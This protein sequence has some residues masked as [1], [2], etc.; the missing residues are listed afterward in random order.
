MCFNINRNR[1]LLGIIVENH[2]QRLEFT[3]TLCWIFIVEYWNNQPLVQDFML[4]V[5]CA[6]TQLDHLFLRGNRCASLAL[7]FSQVLCLLYMCTFPVHCWLRGVSFNKTAYCCH[8]HS[9]DG[10]T[11]RHVSRFVSPFGENRIHQNDQDMSWFLCLIT[12]GDVLFFL[13][14]LLGKSNNPEKYHG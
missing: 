3:N 11:P 8:I 12:T 10:F 5:L 9:D 2:F 4:D 7:N 1:A 14:R 6:N 13:I